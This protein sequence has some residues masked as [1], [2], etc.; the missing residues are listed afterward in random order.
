MFFVVI[1]LL[2]VT[3]SASIMYFVNK[4]L[5]FWLYHASG[6]VGAY[7]FRGTEFSDKLQMGLA[8]VGIFLSQGIGH[9]N[10]AVYIVPLSVLILI[11]AIRWLRTAGIRFV[12]TPERLVRKLGG[13]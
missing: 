4:V 12:F 5:P 6:F 7:V 13:N 10:R 9:W 2:S 3:M 11:C 1:V 8:H